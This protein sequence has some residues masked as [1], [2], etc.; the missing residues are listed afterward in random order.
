MANQKLSQLTQITTPVDDDE[1]YIIQGGQS[2]RMTMAQVLAYIEASTDAD[3][4]G[5]AD[6]STGGL[7]SSNVGDALRELDDNHDTLAATPPTMPTSA[8]TSLPA[9]S[10]A[11]Y[12]IW[13]ATGTSEGNVPVYSD[14]VSW[15]YLSTNVNASAPIPTAD[16]DLN[17]A[18]TNPTVQ[19]DR[20]ATPAANDFSLSTSA[21]SADNDQV[22]PGELGAAGSAPF[23]IPS[24]PPP[25]AALGISS[26]A[27]GV[28]NA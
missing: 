17:V 22:P 25:V 14:G 6:T 2:L 28:D 15:K 9:A 18:G 5:F 24:I 20:Y 1:V 27:P 13:F 3:Q 23:V 10:A 11:A 19:Y 26:V 4:I 7:T 16:L 12:Q 21:P 8:F